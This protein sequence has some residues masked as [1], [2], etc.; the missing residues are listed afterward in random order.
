MRPISV[1]AAALL[2]GVASTALAQPAPET[3]PPSQQQWVPSPPPP[4]TYGQADA[5]YQA[6][7]REYRRQKREYDRQRAAYEAQFGG[8]GGYA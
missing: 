6:Q 3:Y 5:D 7:L 8:G 1:I 4:P 2:L